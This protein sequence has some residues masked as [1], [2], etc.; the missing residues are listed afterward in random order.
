MIGEDDTARL[1]DFGIIGVMT[2]PTDELAACNLPNSNRVSYM[3]PE[4]FD[5]SGFNLRSSNPTNKSDVYSLA[6]TAYEAR[7]FRTA[8]DHRSPPTL[9]PR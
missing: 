2:D 1:A 3:A 7:S 6:M 9:I 5:P 8:C 4:L